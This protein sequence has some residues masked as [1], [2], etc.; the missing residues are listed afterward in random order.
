MTLLGDVL[1][2]AGTASR[3][4]G[5]IAGGAGINVLAPAA[6]ATLEFRDV[7][8]SR[9]D[10][11]VARLEAAAAAAEVAVA[12][13]GLR[14]GGTVAGDHPLVRDALGAFEAAGAARPALAAS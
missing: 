5:S 10:A 2:E 6:E 1:A 12:T 3:N 14:P 13:L 4:V 11:A 7:D 9:L 8:T